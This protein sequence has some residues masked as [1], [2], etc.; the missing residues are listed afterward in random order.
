LANATIDGGGKLV[1]EGAELQPRLQGYGGMGT[2]SRT[3]VMESIMRT[4]MYAMDIAEIAINDAM[5]NEMEK[6]IE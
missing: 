6:R 1:E 2:M 3:A 4:T 5:R